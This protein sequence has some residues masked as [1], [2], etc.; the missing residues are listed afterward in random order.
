MQ[1]HCFRSL[2]ILFYV[3]FAAVAFMVAKAPQWTY[4][5]GRQNVL[6]W[7]AWHLI[8]DVF[9]LLLLTTRAM[10]G[11]QSSTENFIKHYYCHAGHTRFCHPFPTAVLLHK[12]I[13]LTMAKETLQEMPVNSYVIY[14][15]LGNCSCHARKLRDKLTK[16]F[17]WHHLDLTAGWT[18]PF[19]DSWRKSWGCSVPAEVS[20][21]S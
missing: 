14:V 12:F 19:A 8:T 3:A 15:T 4:V 7:P 1:R 18:E 21:R 5:T 11:K 10:R 20:S 2:N 9:V 16:S 13:K 6:V 17:V